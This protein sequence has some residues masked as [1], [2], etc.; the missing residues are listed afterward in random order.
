[1]HD[2]LKHSK[3]KL[4]DQSTLWVVRNVKNSRWQRLR[5]WFCA[6]MQGTQ[7][8]K[9]SE[10]REYLFL[11]RVNRPRM[12]LV[13]RIPLHENRDLGEP[14]TALISDCASA[15]VSSSMPRQREESPLRSARTIQNN[16][17]WVHVREEA[18]N[19]FPTWPLISYLALA[20][21]VFFVC[22]RVSEYGW[23]QCSYSQGIFRPGEG[24]K[25]TMILTLGH[26]RL[27]VQGCGCP[28]SGNHPLGCWG[29]WC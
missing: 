19:Q 11:S 4:W 2:E 28:H 5:Q 27:G 24:T 12:T 29:C 13:G 9:Q 10:G 1:M 3:R 22:I 20:N 8:D 17:M 23:I 14:A 6:S 26:V 15:W 18:E 25:V 21:S 16:C 7:L